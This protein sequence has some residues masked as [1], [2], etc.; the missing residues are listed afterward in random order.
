M[1]DQ[2]ER[3][4]DCHQFPIDANDV[5]GELDKMPGLTQEE[6]NFIKKTI[7]L[8][9]NRVSRGGILDSWVKATVSGELGKI[10]I[11][12][13]KLNLSNAAA[14]MSDLRHEFPDVVFS[15]VMPY[16]C[17]FSV[18]VPIEALQSEGGVGHG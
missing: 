15:K 13:P 6:C 5:D 1:A 2:Q 9:R 17:K 12:I 14:L 8:S 3:T 16:G 7:A 11:S 4:Y 10:R 18:Q